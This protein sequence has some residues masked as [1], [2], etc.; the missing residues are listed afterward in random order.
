MTKNSTLFV[1]VFLGSNIVINMIIK[2]IDEGDGTMKKIIGST[3]EV[4]QSFAI[5]FVAGSTFSLR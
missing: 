1:I 5:S 2:W 3:L 4:L